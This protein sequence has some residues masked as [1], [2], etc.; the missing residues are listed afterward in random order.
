M[1]F[2]TFIKAMI[3]LC[4]FILN[5]ISRTLERN[6]SKL[7]NWIIFF[8]IVIIYCGVMFHCGRWNRST[9]HQ[10]PSAIHAET[11]NA[12]YPAPSPAQTH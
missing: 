12:A 2:S 7:H 6:Q 3:D 4:I 11:N 5:L 9:A 8:I 10:P 1:T